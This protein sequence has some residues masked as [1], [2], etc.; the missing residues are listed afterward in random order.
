MSIDTRE[1]MTRINIEVAEETKRKWMEFADEHDTYSSLTH[2]INLSVHHEMKEKEGKRTRG[3]SGTTGGQS[4]A[5]LDGIEEQMGAMR[6][7]I[8]SLRDD[9][10]R[11]EMAGEADVSEEEIKQMMHSAIGFLPASSLDN[12]TPLSQISANSPEKRAQKSGTV[13]DI[14]VA[15]G[16]ETYDAERVLARLERDMPHVKVT[17]DDGVRRYYQEE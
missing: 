1:N 2:L 10:D 13:E 11:L 8:Q 17:R 5:D 14:A 9:I 3:G 6:E 12:L 4:G 15:L 16:V 7:T